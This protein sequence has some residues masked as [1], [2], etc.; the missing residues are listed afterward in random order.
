MR[1]LAFWL[2]FSLLLVREQLAWA[3]APAVERFALVVGNNRPLTAEGT[4][5]HYADDDAVATH[6]L[7]LEAGVDSVLLT[8]LDADSQ[9]LLGGAKTP[10]RPRRE[11]LERAYAGL[12]ERMQRARDRQSE[13]D[14]LFFY[15]G[16]GDVEEGEGFLVLENGK[17][18]RSDLFSMLLRSP[19]KR[20]HV[21]VDACKS[22][23]V[24][25]DRGPGG[26]RDA[27]LGPELVE[28]VPG[29]LANTGFVLSTSSDRDSHE[30][31]QFQGGI[32]SHELRSALR[33]AA[34][35][36]LDARISYAEIGAF[37]SNANQSIP[38]ARFRPD[39]LV[40]APGG[41]L[42]EA[43][44]SWSGSRPSLSFRAGAWG[45]FY[46]ENAYGDRLLDAHPA[47]Q[48]ALLLWPSD[49]RPLFVRQH[50][51]SAEYVVNPRESLQVSGLSP[52]RSAIASRGAL[53][54]A[55]DRLFEI[56]FGDT[57]VRRFETRAVSEDRASSRVS[58]ASNRR[59]VLQWS[60]G[61]MAIG[62]ASAGVTLS[63]LAL[64][65]YARGADSTQRQLEEINGRVSTLNRASLVCYGTAL[66]AGTVWGLSRFWPSTT[67][68]VGPS[69]NGARAAGLTLELGGRF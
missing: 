25:F 13:V 66:L 29:K 39:F 45:H 15:S 56:P 46:I 69:G 11:E 33:G 3:K 21:F 63:T 61:V 54:L 42:R 18:T 28:S 55:F 67:L 62:A 27:Y 37:L 7:L 41:N 34:D 6:R 4:T 47:S 52:T 10:D 36:N 53:S 5:L 60:S 48:Q 14:F 43:V 20:N 65:Q 64:V 2:V 32:L 8:A 38:V 22:Y 24:A 57:D 44:L 35:T 51:G 9:R 49:E 40:R 31:D 19:A 50:D 68:A 58:R 23:F 17:F 30:W 16:H 26:E 59:R 1:Q 12:L